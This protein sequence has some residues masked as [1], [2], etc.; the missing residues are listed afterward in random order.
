MSGVART[1]PAF[2]PTTA[3]RKVALNL[4]KQLGLLDTSAS[5]AFPSECPNSCRL[6]QHFNTKYDQTVF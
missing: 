3:C 1:L 5:F 2:N 4:V 6:L